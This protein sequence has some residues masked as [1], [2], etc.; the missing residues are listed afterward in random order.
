MERNSKRASAAML[1][2]DL[3]EQDYYAWIQSQVR[4]MGERRIKDIDWENVAEEIEDLGKNEKHSVESQ[5]ARI[6]EHFLKLATLQ[7]E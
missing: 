5:L 4:A 3:Y 1:E 2:S 6:R 7:P